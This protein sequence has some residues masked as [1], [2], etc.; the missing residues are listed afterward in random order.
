MA[1]NRIPKK[2]A[3]VKIPK[4]LR[5]NVLMKS[6]LGSATGREIV[7]DALIAAAGAAASAL[8]AKAGGAKRAG[9]AI[10]ERTQDT[11][12]MIQH[13]LK[14]AAHALTENLSGAAK[15]AFGSDEPKGRPERMAQQRH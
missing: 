14:S 12:E 9:K 15:A 10:A 8:V 11:E 7:A 13:A 3:G 6:L 1:K 5:K 2:I 4:I